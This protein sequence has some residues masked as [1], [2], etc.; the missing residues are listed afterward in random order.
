MLSSYSSDVLLQLLYVLIG[1]KQQ[2]GQKIIIKHVMIL[3][4]KPVKQIEMALLRIRK[5]SSNGQ[6]NDDGAAAGRKKQN[7]L[8]AGVTVPAFTTDPQ[9]DAKC[10]LG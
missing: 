8:G 6:P 3:Q 7:E 2:L 9:M 1:S 10:R 5:M 4:Y